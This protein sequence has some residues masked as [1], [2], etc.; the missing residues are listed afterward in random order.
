[1]PR[2]K[3]VPAYRQHKPSG[4]AVVT[5]AGCDVYL[6]PFGSPKSHRAYQRVLKHWSA[7]GQA[8]DKTPPALTIDDLMARYWSFADSYYRRA[9]EPTGEIN[10][11]RY[12][13]RPL[14][15]LFGDTRARN[16]ETMPKTTNYY[17]RL[18]DFIDPILAHRFSSKREYLD[19]T[20]GTESVERTVR[21]Q[22]S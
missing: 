16:V 2:P 11:I 8:P 21:E 14:H 4:Q 1:M 17:D 19:V 20:T 9:G 18:K 13:L 6:G 3:K 7:T 22:M 10:N 5:V 15:D 12:A